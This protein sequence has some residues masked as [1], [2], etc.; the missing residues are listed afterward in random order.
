[1]IARKISEQKQWAREHLKGVENLFMPS[2]TPTLDGI[3]EEGVRH[4]VRNSILHGFFSCMCRP[5]GF[6][7]NDEY[8]RFI[9]VVRDESK[10]KIQTGAMIMDGLVGNESS[11]EKDLDLLEFSEKVGCSHAFMYFKGSVTPDNEDEFYEKYRKR[12]ESTKLPVI[13]YAPID[14]NN[15]KHGPCGVPLNLLNR[16]ADLPNAVGIKLTQPLNLAAT[17]QLL[18]HLSDRLLVSPVNID[19]IP[20]LAKHY[21]VQWSGFW[22][23]EAVQSPQKPYVVELVNL[24]NKR[25]FDKAMKVYWQLEPLLDAFYKLQAPVLLQGGHPWVHLK[26]FQWCVGGNGGLVPDLNLPIDQFPVLDATGREQIKKM[27]RQVG[28][29]PTNAPEEE[30]IVGKAAYDRGIRASDMAV[31]PKYK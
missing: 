15:Y 9:E 27:Y 6:K 21:P 5:I 8:K 22:E 19:F 20:M 2:Y 30:F 23:P 31:I 17:F 7:T 14:N 18:E 13:F 4:D 29:E 24:L 3:D 12:M 10:E 1:M 11:L 26:Y 25:Q 16:L 28:I